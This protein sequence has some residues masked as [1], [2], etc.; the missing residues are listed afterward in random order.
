MK[1]GLG[2]VILAGGSSRRMGRPKLLLRWGGTSIL[3]HQLGIW[4]QL[5]AAQI[6]VVYAAADELLNEELDRQGVPAQ[7]RIVNSNPEDGMFSSVRC[8]AMWN[9][10]MPNLTHCAITLGDQPHL[11]LETLKAVITLSR[12]QPDRVCQPQY[13]GHAGHPVILP[14]AIF[15]QLKTTD[16]P[17]LKDF[18]A[19]RPSVSCEVSD[20]GLEL[21]IDTPA[22]YERALR[23]FQ[24]TA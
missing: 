18:L 10:W 11:R 2:T 13:L 3:G 7:N 19:S 8:A 24:A 22:D 15:E 16:A 9:G 14:R 12:K 5:G 17:T 1:G 21:D 20:P 6:S 4:Q 23:L